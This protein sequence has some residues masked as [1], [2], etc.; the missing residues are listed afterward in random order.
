MKKNRILGVI[1]A[2]GGSKGLPKKNIKDLCGHPL[3]SYSIYAGLKSKY[4]TRLIVST[5]SKKISNIAKNYGAEVP[6][7]RP[8]KLAKDNI[9]S[10]DALKHAV[11]E[12]EKKFTE[13]YDYIV[14]I[15]AVAP[16]RPYHQIDA[17]IKKLIKTKSDSVIGITRVL[18]K[19]PIRIKKVEKDLIKDFNRTLFEG[20]SS[21]RQDLPPCYVRNGSIYA[22]K[23]DTIIK[24]FSRKG[25]ISRPLI[26]HE[27]Y[28]VNIDEISDL[29]LAES[30]VNR[31]ECENFPASILQNEKITIKKGLIN[32][33]YILI[34]YPKEISNKIFEKLINKYNLIYCDTK[35]IS[36]IQPSIKN[37]IKIWVTSTDGGSF[38]DKK[39]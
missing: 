20:E 8:K 31:G 6:F 34:S 39:K 35:N 22:M 26:M 36:Y 38:I 37:K 23:R 2:R 16:L 14:E 30:L 32:S 28:S 10:R 12:T 15:P 7:M 29:Y 21:R 1:L 33:Q 3:I 18:D 5:D 24:K 9:W 19:H 13:K 17:A 25:R 11:L 27:K 4:L